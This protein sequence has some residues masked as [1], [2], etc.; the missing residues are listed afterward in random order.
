MTPPQDRLDKLG[1]F[2]ILPP[3]L[4]D[5]GVHRLYGFLVYAV[6][7]L[8]AAI[9]AWSA[10]A[11]MRELA[12][13]PGEIVPSKFKQAVHHLEGGIIEEV[14]VAEG[15]KVAPGAPI[16]R[17]K[18]ELAASDLQQL[19]SREA[20]LRLRQVVLTATMRDEK[21]DFGQLAQDYPALAGEQRQLYRQSQ[22]AWDS[23]RR[24]LTLAIQ[25]AEGAL[26]A[27]RAQL[28]S[29]NS[30]I[31]IETE[32]TAIRERSFRLGHTSR[33]AYLEA[34]GQLEAANAKLGSL[35]AEILKLQRAEEEARGA[36][37]KAE[38]E[39]LQKLA[40]ERAKLAGELGEVTNSLVK[41]QDRVT[42]LTAVAPTSGTIHFLPQKSP[43]AVLKPGDLVAEI[44]SLDSGIIAEV[45]LRASDLGHVKVGAKAEV[46]V[47]N[48]DPSVMG[49][50]HGEVVYISPDTMKT[51]N[52]E[53][54][55]LTRIQLLEDRLG[56]G[57][58]S[59]VLL[60]GMVVQASIITGSKTLF[61]Y[62]LK[63]VYRSLDTAFS[64][65]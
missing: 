37:E 65:R 1:E 28:D 11:Q 12:V 30:Q 35:R 21:P 29:A 40:D 52:G 33:I 62:M 19:L 61:Q 41:H 23:E 24:Q 20:Q 16:L 63:P 25:Q 59:W 60:P 42:R 7:F 5:A 44:V 6:A 43:G 15:A 48:Y 57:E 13:A 64:E 55:Y 46:R 26:A 10:F 39:R 49:L 18:P 14:F 54:Y 8:V 45:K 38:A 32:Q 22:E 47:S 4:R 17:L 53:P 36:L 3:S 27:G 31:A 56:H 51:E 50:A 9:V 2:L 58:Q 34:K